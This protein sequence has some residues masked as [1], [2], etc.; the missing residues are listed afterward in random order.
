MKRRLYGRY[1]AEIDIPHVTNHVLIYYE[2]SLW[3]MRKVEIRSLGVAGD[4][5]HCL[6]RGSRIYGMGC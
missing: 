3:G 5:L 6:P 2:R 1:A 4:E